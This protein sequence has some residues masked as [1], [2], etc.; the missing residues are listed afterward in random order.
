MTLSDPTLRD[1]SV[2]WLTF[3]TSTGTLI[4][5]AL[6]IA[7]VSL[8]FGA[9]V[10]SLTTALPFLIVLSQHKILVFGFSAAMLTLSGWLLYR[11]GRACPADP[12]LAA[13]C[14]AADRW[15][16][17]LLIASAIIWTIGF[18]AAYLSLPLL[19]VYERMFELS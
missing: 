1:G 12:V 10:V 16:K 3:F 9:A 11:P 7:L 18:V 17:R 5:C 6:P 14:D 13:K 4:C 8:G 15:N 2:T 19:D